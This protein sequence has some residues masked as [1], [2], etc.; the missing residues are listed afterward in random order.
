MK[1]LTIIGNGFDLGHKL[2]TLFDNFISSNPDVFKQR[3]DSFRNNKNSWNDVETK[4]KELLMEVMESRN[5]FDIF[6]E[7]QK[8][9][10]D[11]GLNEYGEVDYYNYGSDAW[12]IE[13]GKISD[14][15]ALLTQF[16]QDFQR[17]LTQVCNDRTLHQVPPCKAI[18]KILD[19]SDTIINFNYTHTIECVYGIKD[20]IHIHGDLSSR[21]AIG[22]GALEEAKDSVI[23]T[24]YPSMKDFSPTKDGFVEMLG[25]YEEDMDGNLVENHF[26]K[27]FFDDVKEAS[28]EQEL[29]LFSLLDAKSKDALVL[30]QQ[31]VNMLK[32]THYDHVYIIG[33]SLGDADSSVF[34]AINSD[35]DVTCFFHEN[36]EFSYKD[37]NLSS[38]GLK[39]SLISDKGLYKLE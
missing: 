17:Y 5:W 10:D 37:N 15:I 35:A 32:S 39:H 16:E 28:I 30:R 13:M 8:I 3:Y 38:L 36:T 18:Q 21:I 24:E 22:N 29:K 6:E 33:H 7:V 25:Y 20:V 26:I 34:H 4:Y 27:N 9:I 2:P 23:D 14:F 1:I 31:V 11:Y 19:S 12:D